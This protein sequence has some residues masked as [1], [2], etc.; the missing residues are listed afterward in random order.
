MAEN[1][2]DLDDLSEIDALLD[3][4][5]REELDPDLSGFDDGSTGG[6]IEDVVQTEASLDSTAVA[7]STEAPPL[8]DRVD[9]T[10]NTNQVP[11]DLGNAV[12]GAAG[13]AAGAAMAGSV[14]SRERNERQDA[15]PTAE[16]ARNSRSAFDQ[17]DQFTGRDEM[18]FQSNQSVTTQV[19]LTRAQETSLKKTKITWLALSI[20]TLLLAL[21]ALVMSSLA[22]INSGSPALT[23]AVQ[24]QHENMEQQRLLLQSINQQLSNLEQKVDVTRLM[25]DDVIAG[26][27]V[28]PQQAQ[29][30]VVAETPVAAAPSNVSNPSSAAAQVNTQEL[31]RRIEQVQRTAN[32]IQSRLGQ[33][34]GQVENLNQQQ[35]RTTQAVRELEKSWLEQ[36]LA[37]KEQEEAAEEA[38]PGIA[39]DAYRYV[40]PANQF[41]FP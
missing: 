25:L 5:S 9:E 7:Q 33:L 6:T 22:W 14:A 15:E 23:G 40:A 17:F 39:P 8:N 19:A 16:Q 11:R 18:E 29:R 10:D 20:S 30:Q 36:I 37:T 31:Q 2:N 1:N 34:N 21:G 24:V 13:I 35:Q 41:S 12:A 3:E 38:S 32:T 26:Q 28:N 4:V 27:S